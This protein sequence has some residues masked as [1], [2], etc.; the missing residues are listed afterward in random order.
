MTITFEEL[1]DEHF[2]VMRDGEPFCV[3]EHTGTVRVLPPAPDGRP[4][5]E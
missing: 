1:D 4:V 5:P 3:H 2:V